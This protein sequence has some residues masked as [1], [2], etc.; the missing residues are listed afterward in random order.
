MLQVRRDRRKINGS[1]KGGR[2]SP[3]SPGVG[4]DKRPTD[5]FQRCIVGA[6]GAPAA[7]LLCMKPL[8]TCASMSLTTPGV[9]GKNTADDLHK[10]HKA[11]GCLASL[12]NKR[13]S[14][15]A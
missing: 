13:E 1:H 4:F 5:C 11:V 14:R 12:Q 6:M 7:A 9:C 2:K 10:Q 8:R 3:P 15:P